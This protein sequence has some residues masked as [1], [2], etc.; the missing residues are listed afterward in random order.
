MTTIDRNLTRESGFVTRETRESILGQR[1]SLVWL[2]GL[3]GSGKSTI[4]RS[5]ER[6]LVVCNKLAYVLDGDNIRHGLNSDLGFSDA[7]RRENIRRVAEVAGLF[8]DAGIITVT[9]FISP[10]R[11]EREVAR[12]K[13]GA[14]RFAE[15]FVDAP[16]EVCEERDPKS[17]YRRARAG[18]IPDFTGIS[19]LYEAPTDPDLVLETARCTPD[20]AAECIFTLLVHRGFITPDKHSE[21]ISL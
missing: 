16:L 13:V 21:P 10:F 18:L 17:L 20:E 3:S 6:R 14:D 8:V 15:V 12:N 1:G 9:A 11:A 5:L 7:D 2:T 19:S 4:A